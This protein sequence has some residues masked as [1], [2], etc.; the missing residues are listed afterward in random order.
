M[1][2]K[3]SDT[4]FERVTVGEQGTRSREGRGSHVR[5]L[6]RSNSLLPGKIIG[7]YIVRRKESS[8][9][10]TIPVA[11]AI[12][13]SIFIMRL[14]A[15]GQSLPHLAASHERTKSLRHSPAHHAELLSIVAPGR[16]SHD[17]FKDVLNLRRW[18]LRGD[19]VNLQ[20]PWRLLPL[21]C[22]QWISRELAIKTLMPD[23]WTIPP[24][25]DSA[26]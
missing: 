6:L 21:V 25:S 19:K 7:N 23:P 13:I 26:N 15:Q 14:M 5:T 22:P 9:P 12:Q 16:I 3:T 24:S 1:H 11:E 4:G 20:T 17:A 10:L 2:R 18:R 8:S